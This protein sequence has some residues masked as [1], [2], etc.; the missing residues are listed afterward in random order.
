MEQ[1]QLQ[2]FV[3]SITD[4]FRKTTGSPIEAGVPYLKPEDKNILLNYTG[5]IGISGKMQGAIYITAD[6][7]FLSELMDKIMPG[8]EKSLKRLSGMAGELANT[9]AGNAQKTLGKEFNISIPMIIS[10]ESGDDMSSLELKA[11]TFVIPIKWIGHEA[12][13]VVGLLKK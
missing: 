13:L 4:Y 11:P 5:V 7:E 6:K 3:E 9:I 8:G 10:R 2:I 1:E 12:F